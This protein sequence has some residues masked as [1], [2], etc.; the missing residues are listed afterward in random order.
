MNIVSRISNIVIAVVAFFVFGKHI[1]DAYKDAQT[2]KHGIAVI[3]KVEIPPECGESNKIG[4]LFNE[5]KYDI[6]I[7]EE[8]CRA[9]NYEKG[10]PFDLV[11]HQK[12]DH[13]IFAHDIG[14]VNK[15]DSYFWGFLYVAVGFYFLY[16]GLRPTQ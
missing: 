11:Y 2:E 6:Q 9:G 16:L 4:F 15:S 12:F 10:M 7:K 5:K 3:V 8:N 1:S 14:R 13:F